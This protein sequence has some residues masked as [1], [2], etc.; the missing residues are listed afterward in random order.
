MNPR[1]VSLAAALAAAALISLAIRGGTADPPLILASRLARISGAAQSSLII[2]NLDTGQAASTVADFYG[3]RGGPPLPVV[4]AGIAPAAAGTIDLPA[5]RLLPGGVYATIVS[6]DRAIGTVSRTEW[7]ASGG[8]VMVN[9]SRAAPELILPLVLVDFEGQTTLITVQN[10]DVSQATDVLVDYFP[11]GQRAKLATLLV[12]IDPGASATFDLTWLAPLGTAGHARIWSPAAI[13]LAANAIVDIASSPMAVYAA[14]GVPVGEAASRLH[15][16]VVHAAAPLDPQ[17]TG[18]PPL[19]T[20]MHVI[21]PGATDAAVT[22][23]YTGVAGTCLGRSFIHPTFVLAA[24]T[25]ARVSQAPGVAWPPAGASPLPAGCT[26]AA[27]IEATGGMVTAAVVDQ[28]SGRRMAAAYDAVPA[29]RGGTTT[30]LPLFRRNHTARRLT[31]PVQVMNLGPTAAVTT[32]RLRDGTGAAIT[33]CGADCA[34]LI[35][36]G[37]AHLFWPPSIAA[38]PD[39]SSGSAVVTSDQPVAVVVTDLSRS[40]ARDMASYTGLVPPAAAPPGPPAPWREFQPILVKDADI[41]A[42]PPPT[43]T[44]TSP[45]STATSPAYPP[46]ETE[47]PAPTDT[48]EPTD[49]PA[50]T[51]TPTAPPYPPPATGTPPVTSTLVPPVVVPSPTGPAPTV[52]PVARRKVPVAALAAALAQPQLIG[53]WLQ[54]LDP[55]KPAGPSNPRRTALTLVD[56]GKPYHPLFNGL[57]FRVGCR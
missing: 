15:A 30:T 41:L 40:G 1:T 28:H 37:G 35:P 3:Q 8:A 22:I 18:S 48:P 53:G 51:D 55:G 42:P 54:P 45:A 21:N 50:P 39:G 49:T 26:A 17:D 20:W 24:G 13:A 14:E 34:A 12:G 46:P 4:R 52:C 47:T 10:T 11:L 44:P 23:R 6:A 32:L 36:P 25:G 9:G 2:Q 19:D 43:T 57:V 7:A 38:F 29:S 27:V 16:P 56:S 33:G 5:E 31:T